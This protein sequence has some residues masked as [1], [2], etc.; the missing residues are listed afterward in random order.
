MDWRTDILKAMHDVLTRQI[1]RTT[2]SEIYLP[3]ISKNSSQE[4]EL[5]A[6]LRRNMAEL[7]C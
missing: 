7:V 4:Q 3:L 5:N 1:N 2:V 6:L